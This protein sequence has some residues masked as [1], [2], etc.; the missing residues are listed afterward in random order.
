ML[1]LVLG[2]FATQRY[3]LLQEDLLARRATALY[4]SLADAGLGSE[5]VLEDRHHLS[6]SAKL[7]DAYLVGYPFVVVVGKQA[8]QEGKYELQRLQRKQVV[9]Q[10]LTLDEL[11]KE[12]HI[13]M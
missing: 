1:V 4:D 2:K 13:Q 7:K 12:V 10:K 6:Q 9:T 11:I 8:E 3:V 5:V